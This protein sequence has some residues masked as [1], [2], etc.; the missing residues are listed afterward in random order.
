MFDTILNINKNS[1]GRN[2]KANQFIYDLYIFYISWIRTYVH[3]N[4]STNYN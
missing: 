3:I 1:K 4:I 2:I